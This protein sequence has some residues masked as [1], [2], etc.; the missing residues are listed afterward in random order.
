MSVVRNMGLKEGDNLSWKYEIKNDEIV[1]TVRKV[2]H[3]L[4]DSLEMG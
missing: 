4:N 1:T 2:K 3:P